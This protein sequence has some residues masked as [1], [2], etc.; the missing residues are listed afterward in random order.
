LV[1]FRI[2]HL[3]TPETEA[4]LHYWVLVSRNFRLHDADLTRRIHADN[5]RVA[6]QDIDIV[7]AQQRMIA[8]S[9]G[10][11]DMPIRQDKGLVAAHR[12]LDRLA[13]AERAEQP[14]A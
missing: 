9:P 4:S 5:D 11:R 3:L 8:L 10:T 7:E 14:A 2:D 6:A 12:I 13:A 1:E